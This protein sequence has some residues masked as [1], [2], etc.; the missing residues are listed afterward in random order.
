MGYI[1]TKN[2]L[3]SKLHFESICSIIILPNFKAINDPTEKESNTQLTAK[4]DLQ[5]YLHDAIK[6]ADNL[7]EEE[8]LTKDPKLVIYE[9]RVKW[10][11]GIVTQSLNGPG[12]FVLQIYKV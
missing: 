6:K 2:S 10:I 3:D 7:A 12:L 8:K 4:I 1:E 9:K 11:D 5:P